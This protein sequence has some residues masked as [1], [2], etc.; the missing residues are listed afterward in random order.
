MLPPDG[1]CDYMYFCHVVVSKNKLYAD[2]LDFS[3]DVFKAE[4]KKRDKTG[5]GIGFDSRYLKAADL[6]G[7]ELRKELGTLTSEY[8]IRHYGLLNVIVRYFNAESRTTDAIDAL[9]SLKQIQ[10]D[11]KTRKTIVGVGMYDYN[12]RFSW[13]AYK[14]MFAQLV[15]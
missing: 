13:N 9:K 12:E 2:R 1:L 5:A 11:D 7:D 15:E 3:W 6:S 10:G 8:K 4:M 14:Q